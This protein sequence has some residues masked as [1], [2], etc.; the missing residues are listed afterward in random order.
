MQTLQHSKGSPHWFFVSLGPIGTGGVLHPGGTAG[1]GT[2]EA[3]T[4]IGTGGGMAGTEEEEEEEGHCLRVKCA[5]LICVD[6]LVSFLPVKCV[7]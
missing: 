4:G 6:H 1:T 5:H 2:E 3:E 7:V